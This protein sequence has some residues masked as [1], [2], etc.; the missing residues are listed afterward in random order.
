VPYAA[1][2]RHRFTL[3]QSGWAGWR[4]DKACLISF[5]GADDTIN[6]VDAEEEF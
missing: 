3:L 1:Q 6:K 4:P 5:D 2:L